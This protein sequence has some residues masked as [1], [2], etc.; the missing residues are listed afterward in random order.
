MIAPSR[1]AKVAVVG[2]G[3]QIGGFLV[4]RLKECGVEVCA[5]GRQDRL[6]QSY[7]VHKFDEARIQFEPPLVGVD[8]VITLAPL[9]TINV[10]MKMASALGAKRLI[11]FGSTGRFFKT[12]SSSAREQEFVVGQI[13]GERCLLTLSQAQGIA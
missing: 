1:I 10:V 4:L 9:P 5:I 6:G 3:S 2:A 7:V 11:A 8:A 12:S 13:E